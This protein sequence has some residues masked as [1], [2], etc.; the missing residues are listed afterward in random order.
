M[1]MIFVFSRHII[2]F[3]LMFEHRTICLWFESS[4]GERGEETAH[5]LLRAAYSKLQSQTSY[6]ITLA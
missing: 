4:R 6:S 3:F 1:S 2:F 5:A